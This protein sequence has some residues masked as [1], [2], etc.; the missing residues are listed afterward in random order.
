GMD[1]Y[2]LN[3]NLKT[4][5]EILRE[6]FNHYFASKWA[7]S[8]VALSFVA[9]IVSSADS[10]LNVLAVNTARN[11]PMLKSSWTALEK[12]DWSDKDA[13]RRLKR[14]IRLFTLLIGILGLLLAI[15]VPNL[16]LLIISGTSGLLV[17]LPMTIGG[18]IIQHPKPAA[19]TISVVSGMVVLFALVW[20]VP[21]LAFVPA[22][23]TATAAYFLAHAKGRAV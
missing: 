15:S 16:I 21:T 10:L 6:I 8:F 14:N 11:F 2:I 1:A 5:G 17:F 22:L 7:L 19:G 9:A 18:L 13:T 3:P 12:S 23:I 4:E 20:F